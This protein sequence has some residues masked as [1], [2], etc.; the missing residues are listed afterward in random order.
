MKVLNCLNKTT[1]K[2]Y[3]PFALFKSPKELHLDSLTF[4]EFLL[5]IEEILNLTIP[6]AH[7]IQLYKSKLCLWKWII[8]KTRKG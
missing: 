1:G 2:K 8:K 7:W 6:E 3:Q 4:I 5:C